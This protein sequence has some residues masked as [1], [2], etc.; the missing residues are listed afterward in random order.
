MLIKMM[1]QIIW[2]VE[3]KFLIEL[4]RNNPLGK[5]MISGNG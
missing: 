2:A 1:I 5:K 3:L 4:D